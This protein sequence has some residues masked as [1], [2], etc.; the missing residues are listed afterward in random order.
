M[1]E[2]KKCSH[3]FLTQLYDIWRSWLL[4]FQRDIDTY[5]NM[6]KTEVKSIRDMDTEDFQRTWDYSVWRRKELEVGHG[7]YV[8]M[9]SGRVRASYEPSV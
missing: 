7:S 3:K 4:H 6:Q 9:A 8:Q 1:D 5:H 2:Q